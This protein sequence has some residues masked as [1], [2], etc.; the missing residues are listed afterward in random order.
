MAIYTRTGDF[1]ETGLIGGKR[2]AKTNPLIC[3]IGEI[4]ELNCAL[5]VLLAQ[6]IGRKT[7]ELIIEIQRTLILIGADLADPEKKLSKR[8]LQKQKDASFGRNNRLASL[9]LGL[10]IKFLENEIDKFEASLPRLKNF[11]LPGGTVFAA[12]AH[13]ARAI[14]R[15]AERSVCALKKQNPQIL[16]YLNRLSDIL[17]ALARFDNFKHKRHGFY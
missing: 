9:R 6:K 10:D 1:G 7:A 15:R 3:T 13:M 11:I 8:I 12:H 2:V 16:I 4:D 14:C 17:F 5:G